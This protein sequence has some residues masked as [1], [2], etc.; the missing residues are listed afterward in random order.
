MRDLQNVEHLVG[1]ARLHLPHFTVTTTLSVL[2]ES[3]ALLAI[4]SAGWA[5]L[6][7]GWG[8][9]TWVSPIPLPHVLLEVAVLG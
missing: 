9:D 5:P 1:H 8:E 7:R 4:P 3:V 2:I 6:M